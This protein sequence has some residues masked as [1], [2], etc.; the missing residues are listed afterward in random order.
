MKIL[1]L[2]LSVV[3]S[4]LSLAKPPKGP[5]LTKPEALQGNG[6]HTF[7]KYFGPNTKKCSQSLAEGYA[8]MKWRP[9]VYG[10]A[11]ISHLGDLQ[12]HSA[13]DSL[14]RKIPGI[15]MGVIR[16]STHQLS[17]TEN[18]NHSTVY[19]GVFDGAFYLVS[20]KNPIF[21]A[22]H[23]AELAQFPL[24]YNRKSPS[25]HFYLVPQDTF[26]EWY[27]SEFPS[28]SPVW[29]NPVPTGGVQ[30]LTMRLVDDESGSQSYLQ[31]VAWGNQG[32]KFTFDDEKLGNDLI[33]IHQKDTPFDAKYKQFEIG[34]ISPTTLF[35][36]SHEEGSRVTVSRTAY[37]SGKF[38]LLPTYVKEEGFKYFPVVRA[39]Q[40]GDLYR[41]VPRNV[42]E[43]HYDKVE[44]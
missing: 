28:L 34:V 5:E 35:L 11:D 13:L 36:G 26:E 15:L 30:A 41:L 14:P 6:V 1:V 31:R 3:I 37:L 38:Y 44:N 22:Q 2:S 43:F 24:V 25:S 18:G 40:S 21:T 23:R 16:S 27:R 12:I 9:E 20:P 42:V 4:S 39:V 32:V 10:F 19:L 17:R 8:H 33:T 29:Q 7:V